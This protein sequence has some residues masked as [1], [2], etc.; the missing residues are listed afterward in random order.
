MKRKTIKENLIAL[1]K[2]IFQD[3]DLN[4]GLIDYIDFT[5][6]LGMDSFEFVSLIVEIETYFNIIIPDELLLM[7]NFKNIDGIVQIIEAQHTENAEDKNDN[8]T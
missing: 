4:T 3:Y 8:E 7:E 6:D 2:K 5:E 1:C